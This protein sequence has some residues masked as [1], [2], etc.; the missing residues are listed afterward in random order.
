MRGE[1]TQPS[2]GGDR[3]AGI[4][5]VL[6]DFLSRRARGE[7]VTEAELLARHPDLAEELRG[8]LEMLHSLRPNPGQIADLIAQGV[9]VPS[10]DGKY[11]AELGAY[12]ILEFQSRG[13]MGIVLKAYEESLNRTVALKILRPELAD[14]A[15]ALARFEREAKAA[16]ALRHP[17]IVTVYAVGRERGMPFLAME[18]VDGPTIAKVI[19]ENGPM[20]PTT[21]RR[22]FRQLLEALAC[23][24]QAGLVHR[25]VKSAN[26][27]L[28]RP[29][30]HLKLA[31]FGL[32]RMITAQARVTISTAA[33]GTP[34][35]MS[36]EQARGDANIDHRTDLYSAGVVLYEMLTGRTPFRADMPT[37]TI[38]RIL[39]EE[40]QHPRAF[41]RDAD[42]ALAGLAM[43]LM[44]K[45]RD[46][47]PASADE[48]LSDLLSGRPSR[49]PGAAAGRLRRTLAVSVAAVMVV[50]AVLLAQRVWPSERSKPGAHE[51]AVHG[52]IRDV[53]V[54]KDAVIQVQYGTSAEWQVP[55]E[56]PTA[57]RFPSAA[58]VHPPGTADE[59]IAAVVEPGIRGKSLFAYDRQGREL[60]GLDLSDGRLWPDCD[61]VVP[62]GCSKVL[63]SDV[64]GKAGDE[65]IVIAGDKNQYASRLSIIDPITRLVRATF[66]HLGHLGEALVVPDFFE[67][68]RPAIVV[69]GLSNKMDG[70]YETGPTDFPAFTPWDIVSVLMVLDPQ[71]MLRQGETLGPP[72][73]SRVAIPPARLHAYAFLNLAHSRELSAHGEPRPAPPDEQGGIEGVSVAAD[74]DPDSGSPCFDVRV[75]GGRGGMGCLLTVDRDLTIRRL[76]VTNLPAEQR[77]EMQEFWS[78]RWKV[79]IHDGVYEKTPVGLQPEP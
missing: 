61:A 71:E 34:E 33:L 62:W 58:L 20:A 11:P 46:D 76:L 49:P 57:V 35:Y 2:N 14:D 55:P 60:W 37:A 22:L 45:R 30:G 23:A 10:S 1:T 70:F 3:E 5:R 74:H 48:A 52:K 78:P 42:P 8:H 43:R 21:I 28:D 6:D 15:T 47:R 77:K 73:T 75:V 13:G 17:S 41:T 68:H 25:D 51:L 29:E 56:L 31:D 39:S 69:C 16:A 53:Q 79:I 18:Y 12:R 66:W 50:A 40:P 64:D 9:L 19:R 26:L 59:F 24:H 32:A 27:L 72:P 44:A 7:I 36:P 63:A 38:H 65:L 54:S 67:D 4:G